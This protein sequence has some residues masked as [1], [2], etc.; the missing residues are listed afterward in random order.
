MAF[1]MTQTY[2]I[3]FINYSEK[4]LIKIE[5]LVADLQTC[6]LC[7]CFGKVRSSCKNVPAVWTPLPSWVFWGKKWLFDLSWG[8]LIVF[9][10]CLAQHYP[11]Q[12]CTIKLHLTTWLT[13]LEEFESVRNIYMYKNYIFYIKDWFFVLSSRFSHVLHIFVS[14]AGEVKN[15]TYRALGARILDPFLANGFAQL[16]ATTELHYLAT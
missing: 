12:V 5:P 16:L 9:Y 15:I 3:G 8:C 14:R 10:M 6:K 11:W 1:Y 2:S 7:A 4:K 13:D